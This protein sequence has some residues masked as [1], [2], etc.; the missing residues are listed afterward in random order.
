MVESPGDTADEEL[1][2]VATVDRWG[3]LDSVPTTTADEPEVLVGPTLTAALDLTIAPQAT[4]DET[5]VP[6][7]LARVTVELE[8]V[9]TKLWEG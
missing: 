6:P 5:E 8:V 7:P 3:A 2:H 9:W 4:V 1:G